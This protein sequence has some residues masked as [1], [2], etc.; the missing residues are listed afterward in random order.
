MSF[1]SLMITS[2]SINDG[3]ESAA[4]SL[5][6]LTWQQVVGAKNYSNVLGSISDVCDEMKDEKNSEIYSLC[7]NVSKYDCHDAKVAY[8]MCQH[9]LYNRR[10]HPFLLC[11]CHRG[12]GV[13]KK[14]HICKLVSQSDQVK[15]YERSLKRWNNKQQ[16]LAKGKRKDPCNVKDHMDWV[17]EHNIGISHFGIHPNKLI[18][19]NI[20]FDVFHLRSAGTKWLMNRLRHHM[21]Q[22]KVDISERFTDLLAC[23]WKKHNVKVWKHRKKLGSLQG[24]A[25]KAFVTNTDKIIA[26]LK[27][28]FEETE[29]I[30]TMCE[31][32]TLWAKICKF[33]NITK[34]EDEDAYL[35]SMDEFE[36]HVKKFYE[37]GRNWFLTKKNDGDDETFYMHAIRF[38]MPSIARRTYNDH[39]CGL[40]I[41]TMQGFERRNKET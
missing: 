22:Q 41:F 26:F 14:G 23:I 16:E 11:E 28:E 13:T 24:E 10:N 25:V 30:N 7:K 8:M 2:E 6:M 27:K 36:E 40:G 5:D 35:Q 9:S 3:S 33:I 37:N 31:S 17:D 15:R 38:Y 12:E 18:R 32:L 29:R 34:V 1:N 39:K 20:R 21:R 4:G 19:S